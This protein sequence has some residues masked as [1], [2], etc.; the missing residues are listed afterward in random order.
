MADPEAAP[1]PLT[2]V[3]RHAGAATCRVRL[4]ADATDLA[5]EVVDD[6]RGIGAEVVAGVGLRSMRERVEELGGRCEV[7][8]P[9]EGGTWVRAW[10]PITGGAG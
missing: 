10:L 8:C 2:N 5:V 9:D 3:V 6:G 1:K 7:A 4:H